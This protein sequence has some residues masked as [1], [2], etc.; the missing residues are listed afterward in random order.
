MTLPFSVTDFFAVFARYNTAVWPAQVFLAALAV[1]AIALA[2]R[3][4]GWSDRVVAGVLGF[5]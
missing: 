4:R 5:F 1:V 2:L 3:S